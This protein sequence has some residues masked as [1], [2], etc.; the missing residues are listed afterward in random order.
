MDVSVKAGDELRAHGDAFA[1]AI[2]ARQYQQQKDLWERYGEKGR[3]LAVRDALY[4][5][6]A[7]ADSTAVGEPSLFV[8]YIAWVKVV[9]HHRGLPGEGLYGTL[10][11][12]AEIIQQSLSAEHSQR[13]LPVIQAAAD[14]LPAAPTTIDSFLR[15]DNPH[16]A[17]AREYL[18]TLLRGDRRAAG[19]LIG[20]AISS[21][22]GIDDIYL[23]VFQPCQWELGRLWQMNQISV[24]DEHYCT[25]ATQ[26]IMSQLYGY[27][28]STPRGEYGLVSTCVGD[29]MHELGA[30]MV[31]DLFELNGWDTH[32]LGANVPASGVVDALEKYSPDV[33][34]VSATLVSHLTQVREL[35]EHVRDSRPGAQLK[36]LVGGR[37]FQLV[38]GLWRRMG[39]DATGTDA[40]EA[41]RA[42]RSLLETI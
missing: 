36:I 32:Y 20:D 5:L 7:L 21:G 13:I 15:D 16:G 8:D 17:L 37:P 35:I 31:S 22:A 41:L 19:F 9:F 1:E 27:I 42:A 30:R 3:K 33:L 34:A 23:H 11:C 25:A 6:D 4:H 18:S 24:A 14:Y 10:R 2:V 29:E 38:Q 26:L 40:L 28:F 12:T 39:A